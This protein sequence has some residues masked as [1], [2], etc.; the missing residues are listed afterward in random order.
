MWHDRWQVQ[1]QNF[2]KAPE[3]VQ[4]TEMPG[5]ADSEV[6]TP[7]KEETKSKKA[8]DQLNELL[9]AFTSEE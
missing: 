8:M 3:N 2:G 1:W 7:P 4:Q 5:Q 6:K 9:E